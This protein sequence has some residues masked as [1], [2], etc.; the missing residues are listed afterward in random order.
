MSYDALK[1]EVQA[2]SAEERRRLLAF[3]V[4]LEDSASG[5]YA[6]K[7]AAKIDDPSPDRWRTIEQCEREL[8]LPGESK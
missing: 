3:M 7:L 6:A 1:T 4:V 5:G 2:L 8:G